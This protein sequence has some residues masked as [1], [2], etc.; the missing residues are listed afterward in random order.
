MTLRSPPLALYWHRTCQSYAN[1]SCSPQITN[2]SKNQSS[3]NPCGHLAQIWG[4]YYYNRP[5]TLRT[6]WL[7]TIWAA[8]CPIVCHLSQ[9]DRVL[10]IHQS[11]GIWQILY[12]T[13]QSTI[14]KSFPGLAQWYQSLATQMPIGHQFIRTS[15]KDL[16]ELVLESKTTL[17]KGRLSSDETYIQ[18]SW[19]W[20]SIDTRITFLPIDG[21]PVTFRHA[22]SNMS[23]PR[24][25]GKY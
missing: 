15:R 9:C 25:F 21:V 6:A 3:A 10:S 22:F 17:S 20:T 5:T 23:I 7:P 4:N 12:R 18:L 16:M 8:I 11:T 14:I 19:K 2:K 1:P 24:L 13:K